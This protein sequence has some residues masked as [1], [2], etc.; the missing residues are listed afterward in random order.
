MT[1]QRTDFL[2]SIDD[3]PHISRTKAILKDHPEIRD[4]I[5]RNPW[6]F[7]LTVVLV[8][9][10]LLAAFMV[11]EQAWW[12][13]LVAAYTIGAVS[14]HALFVLI[15]DAC[16]KLIFRGSTMNRLTAIL[17]NVPGIVPS[18]VSFQ[19]YHLKHHSFQGAYFQDADMPNKWEAKLIGNTPWGKSVWLLFHALFY[20]ARPLRLKG[21]NF[22]TA[23]TFINVFA[24]LGT[25]VLV[26]WFFGWKAL[27]YL[28]ASTLFSL[29]L[30]PLGARWIQEHFVFRDSQE[31]Y[32]Y[33]GPLNI[34][35]L[36]V[37]YHNEH[38]DFP[39]VPWNRL[40]KIRAMAPEWYN[41]LYYHTSWTG[42]LFKFLTDP[43]ID[44][45][46]RVERPSSV[47]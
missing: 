43:T 42:L 24:V 37:G 10:Q 7:P 25:D 6:S 29:G 45:F 22:F 41:T 39:S 3:E 11:S 14:N 1:E 46:S 26:V 18:A 23:W 40:P 44:L 31:T 47:R 17:A 34:P 21:I 32:S 20:A 12:I 28:L 38:H 36:N 30:H 8:A 2:Q 4:L 5:G 27:A 13:V 9:I 16:H 19:V 33:Y 15:H 35:A